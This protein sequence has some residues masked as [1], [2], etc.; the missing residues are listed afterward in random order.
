MFHHVI[1]YQHCSIVFAIIIG[2]ALQEYKYRDLLNVVKNVS[3][4]EYF[5]LHTFSVYSILST[6]VMLH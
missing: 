6:V 4:N 2:V 3:N 5:R 1:N